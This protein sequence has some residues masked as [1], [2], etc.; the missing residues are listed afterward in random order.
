MTGLLTRTLPWLVGLVAVLAGGLLYLR[1][2]SEYSFGPRFQPP[3]SGYLLDMAYKAPSQS[4]CYLLRLASDGCPYCRADKP[5][6]AQVLAA[7]RR[8]GCEAIAVAP[9]AGDMA[10]TSNPDLLQ[11]RF[12]DFKTGRALLPF[13]VPQTLLFGSTGTLLWQHQGSMTDRDVATAVT[14][15]RSLH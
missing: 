3:P 14:H 6:F 2:L 9:R 7:A 4:P 13:Q 8:Q 5:K 15:L 11:L 1:S 10:Q 12:V